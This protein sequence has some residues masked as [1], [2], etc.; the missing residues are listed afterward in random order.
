[1]YFSILLH[2]FNAEYLLFCP[3]KWMCYIDGQK[4]KYLASIFKFTDLIRSR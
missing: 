3:S 4:S 1:L 2:S